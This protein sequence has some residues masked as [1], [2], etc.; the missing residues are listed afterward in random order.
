MFLHRNRCLRRQFGSCGVY[1]CPL[2]GVFD[3][4]LTADLGLTAVPMVQ[5]SR[6]AGWLVQSKSQILRSFLN[7]DRE[8]VAEMKRESVRGLSDEGGE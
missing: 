3:R 2:A 6:S 5:L 4:P 7:R 8:G 1:L